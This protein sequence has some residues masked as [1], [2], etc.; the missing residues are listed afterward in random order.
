M[1]KLS[2]LF[3]ASML[4]LT[5]Q[6]CLSDRECNPEGKWKVKSTD[7]QSPK[8][9]VSTLE[10][11]KAEIENSQ[12]EFTAEGKVILTSGSN[13]ASE[14]TWTLNETKDKLVLTFPGR[15]PETFNLTSCTSSEMAVNQRAPEDPAKE[16]ILTVNTVFEKIK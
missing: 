6:S 14:G 12:Y 3:F 5:F 7:V 8:L 10:M 4:F 11:T 1:K 9:S 15:E 13:P 16:A 2:F